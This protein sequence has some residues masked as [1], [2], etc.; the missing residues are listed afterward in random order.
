LA[1]R[2]TA[3]P[4]EDEILRDE[5]R[6]EVKNA[7]AGLS[8]DARTA[9]MLAAHGFSGHDIAEALGRSE[10]ATRALICRARLRLREQLVR[11][12]VQP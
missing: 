8:A 7:L 6:R 1:D 5:S 3:P 4:P 12:E 9:L 2:G 10:L 11:T